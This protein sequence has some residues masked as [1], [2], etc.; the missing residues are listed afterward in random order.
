[1]TAVVLFAHGSTVE[2]ANDA[3]RSVTAEMARSIGA[4]MADTAFLDCASP[5]LAESVEAVAGRGATRVVVVPYFL[6]LGIHLQR[7]LPR[8]IQEVKR[9]HAGLDIEVTE[10]LDG[11]P[12]LVEIAVD[13]ARSALDGRSRN[14]S[15][16]D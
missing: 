5:T 9:R 6:T 1:M 10:P 7:D 12:K 13:R 16:T 3:V 14:R 8:I 11:H 2:S 15:Q 4:D